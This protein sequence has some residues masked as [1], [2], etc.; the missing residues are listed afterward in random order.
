MSE[1][2]LHNF[3]S[4]F[5]AMDSNLAEEQISHW[6]LSDATLVENGVAFVADSSCTTYDKGVNVDCSP[7]GGKEVLSQL[8]MLFDGLSCALVDQEVESILDLD[9]VDSAPVPCQS[10]D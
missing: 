6:L 10:R 7:A 8:G 9:D 2:S 4:A 3:S 5:H 1:A